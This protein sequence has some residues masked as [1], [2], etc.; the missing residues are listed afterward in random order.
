MAEKTV[1][2]AKQGEPVDVGAIIDSA[3]FLGKPAGIALMMIIIML[4]DGFDLFI[5]SYVAPALVNDWG[6]SKSDVQ[7]FVQ[8]GLIGM[9][10]GSVILGWIGDRIGR[11]RAYIACLALMFIG[12]AFC[13]FATSISEL[14]FWRLIMGLGLGGVTPL[15]TTLVSEWTN[16]KMRSVVVAAVIVSIPLGGTLAGF[17][18]QAL[19][20]AYG[21]RSMFAVGAIAPFVLFVLFA[22]LLPESPKYMAKRPDLHGKL[23]RMLNQ[24]VREKRFDGTENFVVIESGKQ[25]SNWLATIFNSDFRSRTLLIW[26][27]FIVNS[28]VLYIFT[29]QIPLLL[30]TAN[31]AP[32]LASRGLQ[33]FSA[34]AILGSIGG[35]ILI[36]RFGSKYTGTVL[37]ALGGVASALIAAV[38]GAPDVSVLQLFLLC[39]VA[40]AS[41]NGMQA[42]LYAVSAHSY[43]TE[44]RGSAVGMA[45]TVSRIGA[46]VSPMVAAYYFSMDPMPSVS[47]FFLAMA[48]VI[49]VTVVSFFLIPSHIPRNTAEPTGPKTGSLAS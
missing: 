22:Y 30:D 34:G 6:I 41:V 27:A 2:P 25:S 16:K 36:G 33:Y 46:V 10:I 29:S 28:F 5:P 19:E 15:A 26:L 4:T 12:S 31:L 38:L 14:F 49:V 37:A 39:M 48:C 3:A 18:Y 20:P 1:D 8:S 40:G 32:D 42:F 44:V 45:Q 35:A 7:P 21:W 13:Y 47:T 9:A 23:A 43:P 17:A 24:L 11:K